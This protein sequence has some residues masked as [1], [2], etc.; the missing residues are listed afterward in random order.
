MDRIGRECRLAVAP[1]APRCPAAGRA[2]V[3][4]RPRGQEQLQCRRAPGAAGRRRILA[5]AVRAMVHLAHR[6][7]GPG[8]RLRP[9]RLRRGRGPQAQPRPARMVQ[10]LSSE[11]ERQAIQARTVP[12]G[13]GTSR[14]D[15]PQRR[16]ALLQPRNPRGTRVRHERDH[17]RSHPLRHRWRPLRRLLLP[18][19]RIRQAVP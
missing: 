17:G 8:S 6:E 3:L 7:A 11:H 13:Q 12:P 4:A 16:E 2:S 10:P 14:M 18:L 19:P 1:G 15:R 5:I 9:T